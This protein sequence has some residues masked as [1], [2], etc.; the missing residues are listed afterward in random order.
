VITYKPASNAEFAGK[1][2]KVVRE[3]FNSWVAKR[4]RYRRLAQGDA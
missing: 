4:S 1:S 3:I 2:R